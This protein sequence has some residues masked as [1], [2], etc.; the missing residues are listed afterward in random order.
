V[1]E[2]N[3]VENRSLSELA[4]VFLGMTWG[5]NMPAGTVVL[6]GSTNYVAISADYAA[7]FVQASGQLRGAFAGGVNILHGIASFWVACITQPELGH[8]PK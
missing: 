8:W 5:F 6:L 7:K 4:E 2:N 3:S 1:F